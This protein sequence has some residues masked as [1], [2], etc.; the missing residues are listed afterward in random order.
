[1][2]VLNINN[3]LLLL[4]L[5]ILQCLNSSDESGG[6][7]LC[8]SSRNRYEKRR[9]NPPR[10]PRR[11]IDNAECEYGITASTKFLD[12][13]SRRKHRASAPAPPPVTTSETL[14]GVCRSVWNN[15]VQ[16]DSGTCSVVRATGG[17]FLG[18][19]FLR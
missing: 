14:E 10:S 11:S 17:R 16:S 2:N 6:H 18:R 5:R 19:L 12:A 13:P 3:N 8:D 1:M 15:C 4:L 7:R 9:Q